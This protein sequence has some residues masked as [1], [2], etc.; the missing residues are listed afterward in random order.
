MNTP[1]LDMLKRIKEEGRTPFY[2]PGHKGGRLMGDEA[3]PFSYDITEIQGADNLHLPT[4]AILEA[5]KLAAKAFGAKRTFFLVG[6]ATAGIHAMLCAVLKDGDTVL[7][8][9]ACHKSAVYALHH[10]GARAVFLNPAMGEDN[11]PQSISPEHLKEAL[12][13][14]K[15]VKALYL[16]SPN[17]YGRC[18]DLGEL[19][20]VAHAFGVPVLVDE[21]HG[22]HF[23]FSDRL[24]DTALSQGADVVV[25]SAHKTLPALTQSAYLH[26]GNEAYCE[27]LE[28]TLRM[29][30]STSPSYLLMASLDYAR[31]YMEEH[32]AEFER[33]L[34]DCAEV[35][36]TK[37]SKERDMSRI[38]FSPQNMTGHAAAEILRKE[39]RIEPEM[40]DYD[41]V[42]FLPTMGNTKEELLHLK[43]AMEEISRRSGE[44]KA[45]RVSFPQE[46]ILS[47]RE[48]S[49]R[50]KRWVS[51]TDAVGKVCG[52]MVYLYPPGIPLLLPGE[53]V[54]EDTLKTIQNYQAAGLEMTGI[55]Q[56]NILIFEE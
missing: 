33:F 2:M 22:A 54:E 47:F 30:Q 48:Q 31:A 46:S 36:G 1:I 45:I 14:H 19:I 16:T 42:V 40:A 23:A 44:K 50:N 39:Y 37:P 51:L 6:G 21:A 49:R 9:R 27:L 24:P 53:I 7:V 13:T 56:G 41:H 26:V 20:R 32:R 12:H 43:A 35:F 38:V 34:D 15:G 29:F 8:D 11:I 18:Q 4:G 10:S 28:E 5:E 25:E 52:A 3:S 55:N 17:Y